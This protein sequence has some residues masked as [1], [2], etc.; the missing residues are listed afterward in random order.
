MKKN[1]F[2]LNVF[3]KTFTVIGPSI[4]SPQTSCGY[5]GNKIQETRG[6]VRSPLYGVFAIS[7]GCANLQLKKSPRSL[8][9]K[10]VCINSH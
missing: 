9:K 1:S 6:S 4:H 5:H 8:S 3:V 2:S 10:Q 7:S